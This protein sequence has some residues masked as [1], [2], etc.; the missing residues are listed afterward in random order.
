L[1]QLRPLYLAG[2]GACAPS[3]ASIYVA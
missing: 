3:V 2:W 1:S